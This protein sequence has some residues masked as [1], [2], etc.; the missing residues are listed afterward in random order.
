[1]KVLLVNGSPHD[2]GCT[3]ESLM[4]IA[5]AL[6]ADGI[7]S[8]EFHIGRAPISG[9][10]ACNACGKLGRCAINDV[11]N[12][13]A[14]KAAEAD[15]FVFG[16]PVYYASANGSLISFMDRLFYSAPSE[17]FAHKPAACVVN[18]RRGGNT[19]AFDQLNK[20]LTITQMPVVSSCYWNMTHGNSAEQHAQDAEGIRTMRLIGHNMAWLLKCIEAG[21]AA[22]VGEPVTEPVAWTN[23]IR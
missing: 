11:V 9:C 17:I 2:K 20:Y 18:A 19:A 5:D 15:G 16:S 1:M 12:E 6:A 23:F 3:H 22:G 8:E 10:I 21:R 4:H 7:E 13:F 14:A